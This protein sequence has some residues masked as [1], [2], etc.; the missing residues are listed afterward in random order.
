MRT[1][2]NQD[3]RVKIALSGFSK[4]EIAKE[5]GIHKTTFSVW[6]SDD[7]TPMRSARIEKAIETL[8][9]TNKERGVT[10]Y[11]RRHKKV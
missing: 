5:L 11:A 2:N 3:I 1:V 10:P 8:Q 4:T 9:A 6:L 7:L